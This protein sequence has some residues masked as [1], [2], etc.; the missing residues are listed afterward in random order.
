MSLVRVLSGNVGKCLA[1]LVVFS[2]LFMSVAW[3]AES[4]QEVHLV[5][6]SG[7][8]SIGDTI[9]AKPGE[10]LKIRLKAF[11]RQFKVKGGVWKKN[12]HGEWRFFKNIRGYDV[13]LGVGK[14]SLKIE[15]E[16]FIWELLG[17]K[18]LSLGDGRD[19]TWK[20]PIAGDYQVKVSSTTTGQ[21][22]T[23]GTASKYGIHVDYK[24]PG[25]GKRAF[26]GEALLH[27]KV[28]P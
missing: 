13:G 2:C 14:M 3:E 15:K 25:A 26:R 18:P 16:E 23:E 17:E 4:E 24:L 5:F 21:I 12:E 7:G 9:V 19:L 27:I 20:A 22:T 1:A 6:S 8:K 28:L 11:V 10:D